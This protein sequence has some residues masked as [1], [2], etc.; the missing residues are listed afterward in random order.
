MVKERAHILVCKR[1]IRTCDW[2]L[3]T[4]LTAT[5][6]TSQS[7]SVLIRASS[8]QI[9]IDLDSFEVEFTELCK[10]VWLTGMMLS[11]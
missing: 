7:G 10:L 8:I 4:R 2:E 11:N 9:C 3:R 6:S 1:E 5:L